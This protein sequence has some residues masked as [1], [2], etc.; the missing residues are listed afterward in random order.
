MPSRLHAILP[1]SIQSCLTPTNCIGNVQTCVT[2]AYCSS[3][4]GTA[5]S[6]WAI[7]RKP[8]S[9]KTSTLP[10]T[11]ASSLNNAMKSFMKWRPNTKLK[12]KKKRLQNKRKKRIGCG[13]F[14]LLPVLPLP[15]FAFWSISSSPKKTN[16][17]G[18]HYRQPPQPHHQ[19]C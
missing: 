10:Y 14:S 12:K 7:S 5:I 17:Y 4:S 1:V 18:Q 2:K 3:L 16:H 19:P 8:P 11:T 9:S 15:C 6:Q 13:F